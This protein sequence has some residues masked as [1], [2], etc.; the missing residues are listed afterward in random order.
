MFDFITA[1]CYDDEFTSTVVVINKQNNKNTRA[2]RVDKPTERKV[3][4]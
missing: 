2:A 3:P 1:W 4:V